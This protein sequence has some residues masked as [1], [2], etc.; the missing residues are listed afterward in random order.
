MRAISRNFGEFRYQGERIAYEIVRRP[1]VKRRV[2]LELGEDGGLQV[3]APRRMSRASV[4][5]FL[6]QWA[7]GVQR[8][9]T[10]ARAQHEELPQYRYVSGERHL[11]LGRKYP[12]AVRR[13]PARRNSA[14]LVNGRIRIE[15]ATPGPE[16][17]REQLQR[18]YR[19]QAR[20]EFGQRLAAIGRRASWTRGRKPQMRLRLMKRTWANCSVRGLITF[21]PHLVKAPPDLI[22]YVVAH[23]ICHLRE[24]NHGKAFYALQDRL[25]PNWRE[26]RDRLKN[27]GHRY[28]HT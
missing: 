1:A 19:E 24:H 20:A 2:Y 8:F 17:V 22:D 27:H 28:L 5:Q 25:Y 15:V 6:K 13:S 14:E 12:L 23:E 26:A 10:E 21:N 9:L 16:A 11:Y 4:H 18:F 3:V 7:P